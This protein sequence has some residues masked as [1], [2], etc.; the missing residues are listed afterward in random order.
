MKTD[1]AGNVSNCSGVQAT[2]AAAASQSET[3]WQANLSVTAPA[4]LAEAG[5]VSA[6]STSFTLRVECQ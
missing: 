4:N 5:T 6:A 3:A 2:A 1:S